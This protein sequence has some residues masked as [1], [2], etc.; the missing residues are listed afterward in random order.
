MKHPFCIGCALRTPK[1][2]R[3]C[4]SCGADESF[5]VTSD[6][7][8]LIVAAEFWFVC[9][10]CRLLSPLDALEPNAKAHCFRCGA[11]H[12]LPPAYYRAALAH[13]HGVADLVAYAEENEGVDVPAEYADLGVTEWMVDEPFGKGALYAYCEE[14][15]DP[16]EVE[17]GDHFVRVGFTTPRCPTCGG[18]GVQ[19]EGRKGELAITCDEHGTARYDAAS[20]W[21][22]YKN[23]AAI[24]TPAHRTD[25]RHAPTRG[26]R[27]AT[28][29]VCPTCGAPLALDEGVAIA[30]CSYCATTARVTPPRSLAEDPPPVRMTIVFVGVSGLR[31]QAVEKARK[32]R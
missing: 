26:D 10:S 12:K 30:K 21:N 2:A 7:E 19:Y 29:S 11:R 9:K 13:A 8:A 14:G 28:V 22:V 6:S 24:V 27:R 17:G 18:F 31:A 16:T 5:M 25:L 23:A 15:E 3:E 32:A 20:A 1:K 4:P